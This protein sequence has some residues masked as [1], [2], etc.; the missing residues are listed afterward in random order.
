MEPEYWAAIAAWVGVGVSWIYSLRSERSAQ[1][2]GNYQRTAAE[3]QQKAAKAQVQAAAAAQQVADLESE[4]EDYRRLAE[5][6]AAIR[7]DLRIKPGRNHGIVLVRVSNDGPSAAEILSVK[8]LGEA[9]DELTGPLTARMD[10]E[11]WVGR[12]QQSRP[13]PW[14]VSVEWRDGRKKIQAWTGPLS[15][16]P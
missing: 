12:S 1:E 2:S 13:P 15:I 9:I 6:M 5:A 7:V 11:H 8:I 3:A 14:Y 4:R 16:A 10:R